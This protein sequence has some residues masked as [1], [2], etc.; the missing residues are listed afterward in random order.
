MAETESV[1]SS[2]GREFHLSRTGGRK[3]VKEERFDLIPAN[4]LRE[5]AI[6]Y[7]RGARK[8]ADRNWENG[9]DWGLSFTALNRHLWAW[10][11][12][13]DQDPETLVS[14]MT[15]VAWHAF[16]LAEFARTHPEYDNRPKGVES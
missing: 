5:L 4:P 2:D 7:G 1:I 15:N 11:G 9:Y 10:W 3:E 16:T 12:R 13:E 6:L 14:H 8:Y